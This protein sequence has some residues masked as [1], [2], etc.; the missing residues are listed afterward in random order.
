[1]IRADMHVH[2]Y[3]SDGMQSPADVISAAKARGLGL[4]AVTDHD[5][6]NGSGE[7][8]ALAAGAGIVAVD[9]LE[10]SA[11]AD[12]KVHVLGYCVD[13]ACAAYS[14]YCKEITRGAEERSAD[15]LSKL[16][17]R[18]IRLSMEEVLRER[19]C[20]SSP[21][22][23][24]YIARAA[25]RKG[26]AKSPGDFYLAY[27]NIGKCGYSSVGRPTPQRAISLIHEC[28]GIASLAHPGRIALEEARRLGL[29]EELVNCGLEGIEA[30]YSGHTDNETAYFKEVAAR[31]KLLVTGGSD[32]HY[33]EGNRQVGVPEFYPDG[34][35]LSALKLI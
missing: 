35:L 8:A 26:Y 3:Y 5:T 23:S 25:A 27:L 30:V 32:T 17:R 33:A 7:V 9:G 31:Y 4:I 19:K 28:G 13:R 6:M 22:H 20:P 34:E 11:Y 16:G 1:M 2:T 24:M 14:A 18:G 29:I 15:V 12:V 21:V 10:I